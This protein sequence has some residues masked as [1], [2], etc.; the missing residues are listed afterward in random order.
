MV[1]TMDGA[2]RQDRVIRG[3]IAFVT[4]QTGGLLD[5]YRS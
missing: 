4:C 3:L 5:E 1:Q 2:S